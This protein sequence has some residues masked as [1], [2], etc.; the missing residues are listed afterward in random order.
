M[1]NFVYICQIHYYNLAHDFG[2]HY[3]QE[4]EPYIRNLPDW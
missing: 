1:Y 4:L 3:H 2:Q